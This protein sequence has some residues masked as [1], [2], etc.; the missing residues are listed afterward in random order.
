MSEIE[1]LL[2]QVGLTET[3]TRVYVA[4]HA[5][6][7]ITAQELVQ[8]TGIKR[9]TVYHALHTLT[10]KGLVSERTGEGKSAFCM[11]A[12]A[13]LLGWIEQQKES[14]VQK[15][16]AVQT[17]MTQ[18]AT[19]TA[20]EPSDVS[21]VQYTH[22]K[23]V[24]AVIDLAFY[25][26]SKQCVMVLPSKDFVNELDSRV[27]EATARGIEVKVVIKKVSS[28]LLIYDQKM[29]IIQNLS[30]A[31]VLTSEALTSVLLRSL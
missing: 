27:Q 20:G 30:K 3:E 1:K 31:T 28:A 4:G 11:E 15:E 29:V 5:V 16:D 6:D 8:K 19:G 18:L 21:V 9:P 2:M 7:S 14:L 10:E 26:R 25:A 24:Q 22:A 23:D 17:L 13:K 12:P